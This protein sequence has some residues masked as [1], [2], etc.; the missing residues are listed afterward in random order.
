[1]KR[2]GASEPSDHRK[3]RRKRESEINR[4]LRDLDAPGS[5]AML[6]ELCGKWQ[7]GEEGRTLTFEQQTMRMFQQFG[8]DYRDNM[9]EALASDKGSFGLRAVDDLINDAELQAIGLYHR[10]H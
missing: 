3:T 7:L 9:L 2:G 6:D 8:L 5:L 10:M 4:G 1:M